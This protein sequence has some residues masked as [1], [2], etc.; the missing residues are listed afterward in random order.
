MVTKVEGV[1]EDEVASRAFVMCVS[2]SEMCADFPMVEEM[3][4]V[5]NLKLVK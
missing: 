1:V 2:L 4:S 3:I 5:L